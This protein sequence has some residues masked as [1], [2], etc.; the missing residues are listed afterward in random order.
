MSELSPIGSTPRTLSAK[1]RVA[2][3]AAR[4]WGVVARRQLEAI[5]VGRRTS[6]AGCERDVCS[7]YIPA[8]MPWVTLL[9][10]RRGSW[11]LPS[12]MLARTRLFG[13]YHRDRWLGILQAKPRRL[14]VCVP[15]RRR[16]LSDVRVHGEK[17]FVRI[18]HNRLPVTS[19]AETLLGI[20]SQVR[21]TELR[22]ALAEAEYLKLVTLREVEEVLGRG[23]PG[24]RRAA[25]GAAMPS[26]PAR[27]RRA[28]WRRSSS[29]SASDTP[30][31]CPQ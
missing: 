7:A 19:P 3:L 2:Q 9:L 30:F 18:W 12:S 4:Q 5:G 8:S 1:V 25:D 24:W 20:A 22:R 16:S 14:H 23:K 31:P 26:P 27:A 11:L 13:V 28:C 17:G 15:G 21:F 29:Y 6:C 10:E